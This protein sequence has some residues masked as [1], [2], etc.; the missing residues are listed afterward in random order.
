LKGREDK[1]GELK[2]KERNDERDR[3]NSCVWGGRTIDYNPRKGE[4]VKGVRISIR[5]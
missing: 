2:T 1:E 4:T 5:K 3:K